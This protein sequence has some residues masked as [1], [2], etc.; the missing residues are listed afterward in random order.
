MGAS[1]AAVLH[2]CCD[3][4]LSFLVASA[5]RLVALNGVPFS[6]IGD[7]TINRARCRVAQYTL[8]E[9]RAGVATML[10]FAD[11]FTAA[12]LRSAPARRSAISPFA[13]RS[14]VAMDRAW[15]VVACLRLLQF[16]AATATECCLAHYF[17]GAFLETSTAA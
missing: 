5:A 9:E 11:N 6:E 17:T 15:T 12:S 7:D 2:G 4:A 16:T 13:E 10:S 1:F 8:G 3:G 14:D